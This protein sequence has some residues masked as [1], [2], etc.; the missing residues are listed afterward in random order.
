MISAST[1]I[2]LL[3]HLLA[4]HIAVLPTV[5]EPASA[6][7]QG[8]KILERENC[9]VEF[10]EIPSPLLDGNLEIVSLLAPGLQVLAIPRPISEG[11]FVARADSPASE[12]VHIEYLV[13]EV[14]TLDYPLSLRLSGI[15]WRTA[16]W[17]GPKSRIEAEIPPGHYRVLLRYV[18]PNSPKDRANGSLICL[19]LSPTFELTRTMLLLTFE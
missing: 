12:A 15:T 8:P 16:A 14:E 7:E 10:A 4:L 6:N 17:E 13:D 19:A 1:P 18:S 11:L 5:L 9:P 2:A 3:L